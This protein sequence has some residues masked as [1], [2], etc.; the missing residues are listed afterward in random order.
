MNFLTPQEIAE[1]IP[2]TGGAKGQLPSLKMVVLGIA[3]GMFIAFGAFAAITVS[4]GWAEPWAASGLNKLA[5]AMVFPVG[6]M[7]VTLTGAEL[8]TGNNMFLLVAVLEKTTTGQ[9]LCRNWIIVFLANFLGSLLIVVIIALGGYLADGGTATAMGVKALAIGEAK[10]SLSFGTAFFRG[11]ACNC[12]VC[13]AVW[14]AAAAKDVIGKIFGCFFPIMAF[15][16]SGFEH[17]VAN[18]FFIPAAMTV[19]GSTISIGDF[20]L[21]NLLPVTLGNIIGGG[22]FVG[23]L[24]WA[25]YLRK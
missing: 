20:L 15:V 24:F 4:A 12:L 19:P 17:S 23:I 1:T 6:L 25:A 18:M 16:L 11:I 9:R 10:T 22:L 8:F 2:K 7:L 21:G 14:M 13:L 5:M 3:A